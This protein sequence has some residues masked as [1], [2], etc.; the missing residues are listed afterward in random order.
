MNK[1]KVFSSVGDV[2]CLFILAYLAI[3]SGIFSI[4]ILA[5]SIA[6]YFPR[7]IILFIR[8][9]PIRTLLINSTILFLV[10]GGITVWHNHIS[11]TIRLN[12]KVI[13]LEVEK[14]HSQYNE[15]IWMIILKSS[16]I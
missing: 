1:F 7:L 15:Y 6:Y 13:V 16:L 4:L 2:I 12:A 8:K 9:K 11:E 14:Y 10:F 3:F 5:I